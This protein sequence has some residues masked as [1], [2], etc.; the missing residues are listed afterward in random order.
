MKAFF[1]SAMTLALS[2]LFCLTGCTGYTCG[3]NVPEPLRTVHVAA[4]ENE[5]LYPMVGAMVT[6]HLMRVMA[7]DGTFTLTDLDAAPIRIHGKVSGL[8]TRSVR[9]DRNNVILPNEYRVELVATVYVYNMQTGEMLLNGQKVSA[10]DYFLTR[11]DYVTGI[12]DALPALSAKLAQNILEQLQ[13]IG[14]PQTLSIKHSAIEVQAP[15]PAIGEKPV[16]AE[17]VESPTEEQK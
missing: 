17:T 7:E 15:I 1:F 2:S 12:N 10:M 8:N 3:S 13:T 11:N 6:Q 9:Y 4:F 5:T 14:E 16:A